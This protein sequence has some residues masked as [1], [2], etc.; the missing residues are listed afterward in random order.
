MEL[1]QF[2]ILIIV[3][4]AGV[5]VGRN[6]A[7]KH[8]TKSASL[9][10]AREAIQKRKEEAKEKILQLFEDKEEISNNDVE[11]LIKVSDRTATNYLDELE[12]EG[13]IK[14][15]GKTGRGVVYRQINEQ[16]G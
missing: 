13:L 4:I 14:Q 8:K 12:K 2:L 1:K 3:G 5:L 10:K 15:L 6:L 11:N 9:E 16:D 7:V